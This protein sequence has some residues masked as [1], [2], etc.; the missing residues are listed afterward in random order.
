MNDTLS[1][2]IEWH[3]IGL[4]CLA[5]YPNSKA[6]LKGLSPKRTQPEL[7]DLVE[8]FSGSPNNICLVTGQADDGR[9]LVVID[10]DDLPSYFGCLDID[11]YTIASRRGR[12]AYFWTQEQPT[13]NLLCGYAEI[14]TNGAWVMI[15][16]SKVSGFEYSVIEDRP[17][18]EVERIQDVVK[19]ASRT[20]QSR[21]ENPP[22][23]AVTVNVYGDHNTVLGANVQGSS[24]YF[25]MSPKA[26]IA[27]PKEV[28]QEIKRKLSL[29]D[30][31]ADYS[32][33]PTST[34]FSMS[35]CPAHEDKNK[36]SLSI[37]RDNNLCRCFKLGCKLNS[38]R[39]FDVVGLH[40]ILTNQSNGQS[41]RQLAETLGF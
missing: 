5:C 32:P 21:K 35:F 27:V 3:S 12:H 25:E 40:S 19:C 9:H 31:L 26:T 15:P 2:A 8:W 11:T 37:D 10:F 4:S 36:R 33:I 23:V 29:S 41:A 13:S 7:S 6:L 20:E 16:P 18:V 38:S 39:G 14:K 17:I 1:V 24:S 28:Y 22:H 34:R 30:Y